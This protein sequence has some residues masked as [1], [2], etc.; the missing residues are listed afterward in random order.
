M[1]PWPLSSC[2]IF[3]LSNR[4]ATSVSPLPNPALDNALGTGATDTLL[5]YGGVLVCV[6]VV[7]WVCICVCVGVYLC[8]LV[9][10]FVCMCLSV[11]ACVCVCMCVCVSVCFG[12]RLTER[13]F[14]QKEVEKR[15]DITRNEATTDLLRN[16]GHLAHRN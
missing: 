12:G 10:V 7:M 9:C 4:I 3:T 2:R 11:H 1:C 6:R 13:D 15:G 14:L 5:C 8:M 16:Y